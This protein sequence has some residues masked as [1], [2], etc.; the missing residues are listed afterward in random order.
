M[1]VDIKTD[2]F[3]TL[4]DGSEVD[5]PENAFFDIEDRTDEYDR[6]FAC[7]KEKSSGNPDLISIHALLTFPFFN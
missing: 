5:F 1:L 6:N 4:E 3:R 7:Q 2:H